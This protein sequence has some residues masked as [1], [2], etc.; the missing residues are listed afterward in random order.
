MS[1]L[2]KRQEDLRE[3]EKLVLKLFQFLHY[4]VPRAPIGTDL[5]IFLSDIKRL[6]G[7]FNCMIEFKIEPLPEPV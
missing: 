5:E 3:L 1:E 7:F 2:E 6:S 4:R